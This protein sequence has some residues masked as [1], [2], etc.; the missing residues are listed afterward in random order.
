MPRVFW[1]SGSNSKEGWLRK[2]RKEGKDSGAR[3]AARE[4]EERWQRDITWRQFPKQVRAAA[5]TLGEDG[6]ARREGENLTGRN[7]KAA[8]EGLESRS[9]ILGALHLPPSF[10][11]LRTQIQPL[12]LEPQG[13]AT[14][15]LLRI[16]TRRQKNGVSLFYLKTVLHYHLQRQRQCSPFA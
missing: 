12:S 13:E 2:S 8:P 9:L 15:G 4:P 1:V 16:N 10:I 6:R 14:V 5:R 3:V 11:H 7:S